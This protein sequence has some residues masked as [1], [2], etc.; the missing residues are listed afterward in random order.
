MKDSPSF[1]R[2]VLCCLRAAAFY[3]RRLRV[4]ATSLIW[5]PQFRP[6]FQNNAFIFCQGGSHYMGMTYVSV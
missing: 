6:E 1:F 5:Q 4:R 3:H 2:S